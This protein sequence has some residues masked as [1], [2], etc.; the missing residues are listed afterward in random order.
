MNKVLCLMASAA[1]VFGMFTACGDDSSSSSWE[2]SDDEEISSSSEKTKKSSSSEKVKSSSSSEKT[3]SSSSGKDSSSSEDTKISSSSEANSSSSLVD[4]QQKKLVEKLGVCD[5]SNADT[6]VELEVWYMCQEGRWK[7]A[8][9][10]VTDTRLRIPGVSPVGALVHY[11]FLN[12]HTLIAEAVHGTYCH[13]TLLGSLAFKHQD[14][15][16]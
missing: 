11:F 10:I 4:M 3:K 14:R 8:D 15:V 12:S 7:P 9:A 2:P 5:S 13:I 6:L 16:A 1:L